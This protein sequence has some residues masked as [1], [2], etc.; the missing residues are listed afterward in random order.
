MSIHQKRTFIRRPE[1]TDQ[2]T[3]DSPKRPRGVGGIQLNEEPD[4]EPSSG[5]GDLENRVTFWIGHHLAYKNLDL[6]DTLYKVRDALSS[7][8][9][10]IAELEA[11]IKHADD[12]YGGH[13]DTLLAERDALQE[14]NASC[15]RS[16]RHVLET[17]GASLEEVRAIL[18]RP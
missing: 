13:Y 18:D 9:Q 16:L 14:K 8:A 11:E 7:D 17:Q 5:R 3:T 12:W 1:P 4:L 15:A 2:G 6:Q 10:R